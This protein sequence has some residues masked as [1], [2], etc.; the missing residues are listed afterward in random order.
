MPNSSHSRAAASLQFNRRA[1]VRALLLALCVAGVWGTSAAI[2][3]DAAAGSG[4]VP[5]AELAR[6]RGDC[7]G[8]AEQYLRA[9]SGVRDPRI[10]RR[11]TELALECEQLGTAERA[12]ARWR[13]LDPENVDALRAA[14]LL[15]LEAWRLDAASSVFRDLLAKPDVEP[16]RALADLLPALIE[17]D[18]S[19][20]AWAVFGPLV[21]RQRA[22]PA[23]LLALARLAVAADSYD[24]ARELATQARA[25]TPADAPTL[26]LLAALEAARGDAPAALALAQDAAR[27]GDQ[28][29]AFTIAEI[30]I[31]LDRTEEAHQELERLAGEPALADEADRRLALLAAATGDFADS[32]RRFVARLRRGAGAAEST[33]YLGLLAERTGQ[34][35]SALVAYRGLADAGAGLAPRVRAAAILLKRNER[36]AAFKL[37]DD[38]ARANPGAAVDVAVTRSQ[39]LAEAA[40]PAEALAVVDTALK[41]YPQHH[42]L[43]Y[44]RAMVL[45]RAGK[46]RDAVRG[47][48]ALSR[49][50][51]DDPTLLN[52][53]GYTLADRGQQLPR[54]EQLIQRAVDLRPDSA[55]FLDS[56]AWVKFR[57]GDARGALPL[58]ERAWAL[59]RDAEI[60][61]HWGEVL[62]TLGQ[63]TEARTVWA[64]ALVRAPDSRPL[65]DTVRRLTAA[66]PARP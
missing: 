10:A 27:L 52:A 21:D 48:E 51:V 49:S 22:A 59:S 64:R 61:A 16:D 54:A 30:L 20:A 14:G 24:A 63:R 44:Q 41:A 57:R 2:E 3:K 46:T 23:T 34:P 43:R 35:D 8:A 25:R 45:E 15:A 1:P 12:A 19:A 31:D 53:L 29:T 50:R 26:K 4:L 62:W 37:I 65:A 38:F 9:A 55:A 32:Q 36:E 33:Y 60:A 6:E 5:E 66:E 17:S 11:A 7:R 28:D 47:L 56:L 58:L 40:A 42:E 18:Q 39:L 13:V